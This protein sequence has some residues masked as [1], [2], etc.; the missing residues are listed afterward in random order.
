MNREGEPDELFA[1]HESV[2]PFQPVQTGELFELSKPFGPDEPIES[3]Q[4][5]RPTK[6]FE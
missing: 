5:F 3:F 1:V 2:T 4:P 6:L